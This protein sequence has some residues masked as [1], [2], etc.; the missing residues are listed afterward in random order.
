MKLTDTPKSF[1]NTRELKVVSGKACREVWHLPFGV[2][3]A[4]F[5][6]LCINIFSTMSEWFTLMVVNSQHPC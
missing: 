5:F 4:A 1:R 6:L 2:Y 3:Q